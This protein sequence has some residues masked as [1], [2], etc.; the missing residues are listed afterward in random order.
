M[1]YNLGSSVFTKKIVANNIGDV[2]NPVDT[3]YITNIVPPPGGAT[4]NLQEV[5]DVDSTTTTDVELT[6]GTLKTTKINEPGDEVHIR[7]KVGIGTDPTI[8]LTEDLEVD[9]NIQ[10]DTTGLGKIVFYDKQADHEH[11]EYD[12]DDD[13]TNGGQLLFKTK[14]DGGSVQTRMV[15]RQSG[16]VGI[17]LTTPLPA[18]L[19]DVNG[20]L[21]VRDDIRTVGGSIVLYNTSPGADL[22]KLSTR[23]IGANGGMLLLQTKTDGGGS[24]TRV[25]ISE[26]GVGIGTSNPQA[27]LDVRGTAEVQD[28]FT[29]S[30]KRVEIQEY[31][32]GTSPGAVSLSK[33]FVEITNSGTVPPPT[34]ICELNIPNASARNWGQYFDVSSKTSQTIIGSIITVRLNYNATAFTG[35]GLTPITVDYEQ[36]SAD[37]PGN[38]TRPTFGRYQVSKDYGGNRYVWKQVIGAVPYQ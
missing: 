38:Y 34:S 7:G 9:G 15:I 36:E 23:V 33:P 29:T 37:T 28:L 5:C 11:G 8:A 26:D 20:A 16:Q 22:A 25:S 31:D 2:N 21:A 1:S 30:S 35:G 32:L 14:A 6:T 17:G 12:A 4:P 27:D 10:I 19:L 18:H 24:A 3:A 13:G